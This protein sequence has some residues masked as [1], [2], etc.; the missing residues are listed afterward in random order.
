[1]SRLK[2][3]LAWA[4][5]SRPWRAWQRFG[6][7][8]GTV[9]AG[10]VTYAA[11][12]SLFP[13]LAAGFSIFGLILGS[14]PEMQE[15]VVNA[16]NTA[17][18]T[19]I[20]KVSESDPGVVSLSSL[21]NG[22]VLSITGIIALAG[23]LY[24][25]LG[26]LDAMREGIRAMFGQERAEGNVV[27]KKSQDVVVLV[28]VGLVILASAG[29]GLVVSSAA[30]GLLGSVGLS[31]SVAGEVLIGVLSSVILLFVDATVLVI[32][33]RVLAGLHLPPE[34]LRDSALA[35]AVAL[36]VLKIFAGFLLGRVSDNRFLATFAVALGLLIWLNLM[37]RVTLLSAAW[38]AQT[39][40]DRGHLV[41][42]TPGEP[43]RRVVA[44][45]MATTLAGA[46]P[47]PRPLFTPVVSPRAADRVSVAA[48]A[49]LGM[50]AV[51]AVRV[52]TGAVRTVASA[53]RHGD[54]H[55]RP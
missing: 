45:A 35:G 38:A 12:F 49:I 29:T 50:A 17:F 11:F 9:L 46:P 28:G 30:D 51:S 53:A 31:G 32:L 40:L 33:F 19:P 20:I 23:L 44:L 47:E 48:G 6:R 24:T 41:D 14:D 13:A 42:A 25:G 54:A 22:T 2:R 5:A 16:V 39:A 21:T 52:A 15:R 3:L 7:A 43:S 34:D 55:D 4:Q 8:R 27:K 1:V 18:G 26:W 10:G 36:G 37:S